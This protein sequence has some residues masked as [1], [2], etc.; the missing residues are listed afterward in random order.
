MK[1]EDFIQHRPPF[2]VRFWADGEPLGEV[3]FKEEPFGQNLSQYFFCEVCD[4]L[5][6]T[7]EYPNRHWIPTYVACRQHQDGRTEFPGSLLGPV[8]DINDLPPAVIAREFQI[9]ITQLA[10]EQ[11]DDRGNE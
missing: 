3:L 2:R 1:L 5:W 11:Q 10:K 4:E 9:H 6:G 7:I 8:D